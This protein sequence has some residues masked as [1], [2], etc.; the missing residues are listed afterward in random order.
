M[1]EGGELQIRGWGRVYFA[2]FYNQITTLLLECSL[3]GFLTVKKTYVA[4]MPLY[5][6]LGYSQVEIQEKS[7]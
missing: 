2:L 4:H 6:K 7:N 3:I 5:Y 1:A